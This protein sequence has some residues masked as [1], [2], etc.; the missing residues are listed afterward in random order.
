MQNKYNI[1][2]DFLVKEYINNEKSTDEIAKRLKC[3]HNTVLNYLKKYDIKTRSK[4]R[5]GKKS[6]NYKHGGTLKKH[7]CKEIGCNNEITY[8]TVKYG[9]GRC[10]PCAG[11]FYGRNEKY[12]ESQGKT[13]KKRWQDKEYREK[14]IKNTF[15][16]LK[17]NNISP[18]K[19]EKLLNKI[20]NRLCPNEYKYV[21]DGKIIISGFN[22]DFVHN[23]GSKKIIELYGDYWHNREDTKKRDKGRFHAYK[24]NG[25]KMLIIWEHELE[26]LNKVE[27]RILE[28]NKK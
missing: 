9:Q 12:R 14:N 1:T 6:S 8:H 22:P 2:K 26:N 18:N 15:K 5:F 7:Y 19:P 20:L 25:Y 16:A 10:H 3:V 11:K 13:S 24:R 27:N 4:N 28:F 17:S 21:G 23:N